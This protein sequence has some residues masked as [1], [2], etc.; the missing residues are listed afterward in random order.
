MPTDFNLPAALPTD[1]QPA[2]AAW[3][4]EL[5]DA[6]GTEFVALMCYGGLA[7][8]DFIPGT[9]DVNLLAVVTEAPPALLERAAPAIRRGTR[10]HHAGVFLVTEGE[11][12]RATDVFPVKLLD[13]KRHHH[14][15]AG[16]DVT[17]DLEI[18][19]THL[20]LRC[21]QELRDLLFSLRRVY[22]HQQPF[23]EL[24]ET[25]LTRSVSS[26]VVNLGVLMELR[27]GRPP[28]DRH[29]ILAEAAAAGMN[30][31]PIEAV[32]ALRRGESQ[33]SVD[34]LRPLFAG[35]LDTLEQV[36]QLA[37]RMGETP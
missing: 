8:G 26:L 21:E 31:A 7:R 1:M 19:A 4:D 6:L 20:R 30:T 18:N 23:P 29:T 14:L 32:M 28:T 2:L 17:L 37:D 13:I 24:L 10:D 22:V 33:P 12:R 11:L 25:S 36:V 5:R 3:L 9:S 34:A 16:R 27:T 35:F 15:L